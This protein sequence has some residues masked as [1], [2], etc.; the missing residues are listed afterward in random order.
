MILLDTNVVSAA[1]KPR[2]PT[3]VLAW[4]DRQPTTELYLSTITIAEISFGLYN[5]PDG[6]RRR[7]LEQ[8]FEQVVLEGFEGRVLSFELAAAHAYGEIMGRRKRS[9]RPMSPL[10]GQIAAIA[11][12]HRMSVATRN[13]RDFEEC[14]LE[15]V[16]PFEE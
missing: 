9:G 3:T 15:I 4:I 10:D 16:D 2:A 13:G 5:L 14:G 8:R 12:V 11:R 7:D 1:M 6:R